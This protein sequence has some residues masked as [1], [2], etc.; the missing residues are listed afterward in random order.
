MFKLVPIFIVVFTITVL[1]L[2]GKLLSVIASKRDEVKKLITRGTALFH[3]CHVV[4]L[5]E[6]GTAEL[7]S[8]IEAKDIEHL[9]IFIA[10]KKP[11]FIELDNYINGLKEQFLA[12]IK[13]P[14]RA[15]SVIEKI[16]AASL[17]DIS[18]TPEGYD[19]GRLTKAELRALLEYDNKKRRTINQ[20][21]I[22]RF[23]E[24]QFMENFAL[25]KELA[26]YIP[27]TVLVDKDDSKRKRLD[28]LVKTGIALQGRKIP[29]QDRLGVL[30]LTQLREMGKEL[31]LKQEFKR[32]A[33]ATEALA[34][35]PGSAILL[36]MLVNIDDIFMIKPEPINTDVVDQEW[37]VINSYA[38]LL[39]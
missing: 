10:L 21:F 5:N 39:C 23:G 14:A 31:N 30:K 27:V 38:K 17:I 8:L 24:L 3:N 36:A 9:A 22:T 29:L 28:V 19:F 4:G 13:K 32:R 25:Y 11:S 18:G 26:S 35:I 12:I 37:T 6:L 7:K 16:T 34:D 33:E 15:A 1:W 2:L 20:E